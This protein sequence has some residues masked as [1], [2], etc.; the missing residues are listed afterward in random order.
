MSHTLQRLARQAIT[1]L[2]R[3]GELGRGL[4][5]VRSRRRQ[6][7]ATGVALWG[8]LGFA[9]CKGAGTPAE[10]EPAGHAGAG[11]DGGKPD[12]MFADAGVD[13]ATLD[14]ESGLPAPDVKE[15]SGWHRWAYTPND[16]AIFVPD[17]LANVEPL[18]WEPCPFQPN[19]CRR[20]S[21]SND[22]GDGFGAV[23]AGARYDGATYMLVPRLGDN[24]YYEL[25][26]LKDD[27]VIGAWK[28]S[29][30]SECS[31]GVW[32]GP[33]GR[34]A[35]LLN[36]F[37]AQTSP[38]VLFNDYNSP[39]A[40][41]DRVEQFGPPNSALLPA[42]T[43]T[44][45]AQ[46]LVVWE[47]LRFGVRDLVS[48]T[49]VQPEPAAG[50]YLLKDP[51]PVGGAV[52]YWS[53]SGTVGSL[54]AWQEKSGS[55]PV[56]KDDTYS[57]DAF[58]SDG[59]DGVWLRSHGESD[60]GE[61]ETV[62]LFTSPLSEDPN[63]L[64]PKLLSADVGHN[65]VHLTVGAGWAAVRL[66][67]GKDVRL[68]PIAGGAAKR[69]PTVADVAWNAAQYGGMQIVGDTVWVV[70]RLDPGSWQGRYLTV[71]DISALPNL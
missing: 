29:P 13:S 31:L 10:P 63:T 67:I 17:D 19:G 34:F 44:R 60:A 14:A 54:W 55:V 64:S 58:V 65:M 24:S 41:P 71:F 6:A 3:A 70:G 42:V 50:D 53:W 45:S 57:Y 69:L 27:E 18:V 12:G 68:Y 22:D 28:A 36:R 25:L 62:E 4:P 21:W 46:L 2:N 37:H 38:W 61:Y 8:C 52:Y 30:A 9:M 23:I 11:I 1:S 43:V 47:T 59:K 32:P 33:D 66:A 35:T 5:W 51:T 16:C 7:I 40:A 15:P 39:F 20:A 48:G 49:T 26:L 56:L